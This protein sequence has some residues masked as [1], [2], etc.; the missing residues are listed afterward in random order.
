M[1]CAAIIWTIIRIYKMPLKVTWKKGMRLTTD[2]F[3]ALDTCRDESIRLSNIIATGRR[4]GLIPVSKPFE[5][6]VNVSNN[7]LE[8]VSLSC[9][10]VTKSGR[11]VDID[12]DSAYTNTF[13][14]RLSMPSSDSGEAFLLVIRFYDRE[15]REVNEMYS[16]PR[17]TFELIGENSPVDDDSLPIGLLVNQYG[18]RLDETDFVPPCLY[19]DSH[20]KFEELA[21]RARTLLKSISDICLG[22]HNCVAR[23]LLGAV[24]PAVAESYIYIDKKQESL[25]PADL[26]ASVQKVIAAFVIGCTIDEYI[27]LEQAEP[28]VAYQQRPY[29]IRNLYRDIQKGLELCSEIS[30]K[31]EAVCSMTEV[32]EMPIHAVEKPKPGPRPV[33]DPD[34]MG[35]RRWEGIEI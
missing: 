26:F 23:H 2:V 22:A 33:P 20:P 19:A 14:T 27:T 24:W 30:I 7:I 4:F 32:R 35:R 11:I 3:D 31:M 1:N 17:Y 5:L 25:S 13:D 8:I 15:W 18:W 9:H 21:S 34:P 6:S 28:F 29:S 12:F 16:E 10:G